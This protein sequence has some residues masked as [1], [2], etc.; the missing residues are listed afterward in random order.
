MT[1]RFSRS[2]RICFSIAA[3]TSCGGVMFLIS[4]RSTLMPH[5]PVALSSSVITIPLMWVRSSK[6]RSRSIL[7]ISE[8]SAVCASWLIA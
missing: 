7:P 2:A 5:G 4:Y 6:V 1:A 8:R 3:S